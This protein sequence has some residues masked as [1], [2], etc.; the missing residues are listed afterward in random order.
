MIKFCNRIYYNL[1]K[2]ELLTGK[3]FLYPTK[4]FFKNVKK[5]DEIIQAVNEVSKNKKTGTDVLIAGIHFYILVFFFILS[6]VNFILILLGY[7]DVDDKY[8]L[9]SIGLISYLYSYYLV[10]YKDRYLGY[11]E[12]FEKLS[13]KEN[14]KWVLISLIVVIPLWFLGF[15]SLLFRLTL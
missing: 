6:C 13:K 4:L 2:F 5:G 15:G 14:M 3:L 11:F 12:D 10:D 8:L 7:K 1:Y 9:M